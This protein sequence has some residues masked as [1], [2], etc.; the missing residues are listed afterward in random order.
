MAP[1]ELSRY[2]RLGF[3]VAS[4]VIALGIG[5]V[6]A[7]LCAPVRNVGPTFSVF[8]PVYGKRLKKS[9][10][11]RRIT[12]EFEMRLATN[13]LGFRGPEPP[14]FPHQ[15]VL[16]LGDSFTLGY[17]VNDGEEYPEIVRGAIMPVPVV[18]AG[19]GNNGNGVWVKFLRREALRFEPRS[20][21]LQVCANDFEDNRAER[22]FELETSGELRELAPPP[23]TAARAIQA[24]IEAVPGLSYSYLVSLFK[25]AAEGVRRQGVAAATGGPGADLLTYRLLEEALRIC[26]Q[27]RWPVIGLT[28]DLE[29]ERLARVGE[30]FSS[31]AARVVEVPGK[32]ERP[33]LY[34]AVDAHWNRA[35]HALAA[36]LVLEALRTEGNAIP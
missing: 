30:L 31:F 8:D 32:R 6:V 21:V 28:G 27:H 23:Q 5:E 12:P 20:V 16:F 11:C 35:G 4:C 15:P 18:N 22:L 19:L 3:G 25:Q 2:Q 33:D 17:G 9:F 26:R 1:A 10:R 13:S 14:A 34:Y 7:R 24:S 36:R 29:G